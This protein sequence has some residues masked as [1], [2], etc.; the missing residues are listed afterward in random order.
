LKSPKGVMLSLFLTVFVAGFCMFSIWSFVSLEQRY[1]CVYD[2]KTDADF[3]FGGALKNA[4]RYISSLSYADIS[5]DDI[6]TKPEN[7]W[8]ISEQRSVRSIKGA[9]LNNK[10]LSHVKAIDS[11]LKNANMNNTSLF[12]GCF[13]KADLEN[14]ELKNSRLDQTV[15]VEANLNSADL[16]YA[17]ISGS[18]VSFSRASLIGAD[19]SFVEASESVNFNGA[20][21]KRANISHVSLE[22][23]TFNNAKMSNLI[24]DGATLV[25]AQFSKAIIE[26]GS[27]ENAE[28]DESDFSHATLVS[29]NFQNATLSGAIL[30][31]AKLC[32]ANFSGADLE[33]AEFKH[34]HFDGVDLSGATGLD[35]VS[36]TDSCITPA[37]RQAN[38]SVHFAIQLPD[39]EPGTA[40]GCDSSG[41]Q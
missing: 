39:C 31:N 20:E 32:G 14:A 30:N 38:A 21:M 4:S 3:S 12:R 27:F 37:T 35:T 41:V 33:G 17:T 9:S 29:A 18:D 6:S 28:L 19:F 7:Y 13:V 8:L 25:S 23:S 2:V 15:F 11:F 16:R 34:V 40:N 10:N 5:S 26:H 24:A 36:V 1:E 22:G